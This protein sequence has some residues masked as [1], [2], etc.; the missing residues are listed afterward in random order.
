MQAEVLLLA[1]QVCNHKI[2]LQPVAQ[3]LAAMVQYIQYNL[4][5]NT[6]L[7]CTD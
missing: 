5:E 2:S 3:A 4:V 7:Q 1:E 6:L